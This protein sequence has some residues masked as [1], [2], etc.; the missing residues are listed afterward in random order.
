MKADHWNGFWVGLLILL[1]S[2]VPAA[3]APKEIKIVTQSFAPLQW[4]NNG[5]PDGYVADYMMAVF[6]RVGDRFPV[7]VG[8]FEFMPWKRAMLTASTEPDVML[9][10][11]SRMPEREDRFHWLGEVSP[12]GQ[13]L[14]QRRTKPEI[15]VESVEDLLDLELKIG[16]QDGGSTHAYLKKLGFEATG[17]LVP[18]TDYRQGI[19]MLYLDRID[20]LP[21]TGFL[22]QASSCKQG[23]DGSQLKPVV[24]ID[25]LAK[26]LWAVFSKETDPE[27]A[28]V[29][30]E[31]MASLKETGY[32]DDLT[33]HHRAKWQE[34]ACGNQRT[35]LQ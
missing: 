19:R 25:D 6:D 30:R 1:F 11:V 17:N 10:S 3:S 21:L 16:V 28:E 31:E 5:T 15:V 26:P 29:F 32:L 20:V 27:L 14:F 2:A 33:K 8:S 34:L 4:E 23:F 18:I 9:F 24:F 13:Y 7:K 35:E 22:A 12:Y